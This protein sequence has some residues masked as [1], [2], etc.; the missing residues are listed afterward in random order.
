MKTFIS[1]LV[2]N[3][4]TTARV[5]GLII[6]FIFSFI[7]LPSDDH[8]A[9]GVVSA[10]LISAAYYAISIVAS[11]TAAETG[12]ASFIGIVILL[13]L[14]YWFF[15]FSEYSSLFSHWQ[16][17]GY[18][19][20]SAGIALA[21]AIYAVINFDDVCSLAF[22]FNSS[23]VETFDTELGY[24]FNRFAETFEQMIILSSALGILQAIGTVAEEIQ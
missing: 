15:A 23:A 17:V 21:V 8:H 19:I 16:L 1:W 14:Y 2:A 3:I 22:L 5:L 12:G 13:V 6:I 18:P 10:V 9:V 20:L 11:K 7:V 4:G 24:F